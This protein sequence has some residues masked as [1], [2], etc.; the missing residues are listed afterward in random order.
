[1]A[2]PREDG[3]LAPEPLLAGAAD[4]ATMFSSLTAARPSNRPSQRSASQTLPVPPW[5][6]RRQQPVRAERPGP[7]A[8][9]R[10]SAADR[11]PARSRKRDSCTASCSASIACR[12]AASAA[13]ARRDRRQPRGLLGGLD[14]ERLVEVRAE[15]APPIRADGRHGRSPVPDAP[16]P[17]RVMQIQAALLPVALDGPFRDAAHRGNLG[18]GEAAEELQVDDLGQ[19]RLDL[20]EL[21]ERIADHDQRTAGRSRCRRGRCRAR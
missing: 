11:A 10:A 3:A 6:M 8:T 16:L 4:R 18:E 12:S 15:R 7:P 14:I 20:G 17:M 19:A 13:I 9:A 2:Q 21:V 1:M 5:P